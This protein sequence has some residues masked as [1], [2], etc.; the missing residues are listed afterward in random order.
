MC[1]R[2]QNVATAWPQ[3]HVGRIKAVGNVRWQPAALTARPVSSV[4]TAFKAFRVCALTCIDLYQ[5]F[6]TRICLRCRKLRYRRQDDSIA[7]QPADR[8]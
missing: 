6:V 5:N 7:D 4:A 1:N 3:G 2:G 8:T